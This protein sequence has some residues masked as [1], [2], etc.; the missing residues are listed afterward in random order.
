MTVRGAACSR[1]Q[2][3]VRAVCNPRYRDEWVY[4]N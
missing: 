4:V 1:G 3:Y 2:C